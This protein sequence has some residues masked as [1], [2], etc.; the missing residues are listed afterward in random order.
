MKV[1]VVRSETYEQMGRTHQRATGVPIA[2][3]LMVPRFPPLSFLGCLLQQPCSV[4]VGH[5]VHQ[6]DVHLDPLRVTPAPGSCAMASGASAP[7]GYVT[8]GA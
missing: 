5:E 3:D 8:N 7:G 6:E 4:L 2:V 1:R